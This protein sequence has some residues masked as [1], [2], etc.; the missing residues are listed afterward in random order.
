MVLDSSLNKTYRISDYIVFYGKQM[1]QITSK[2]HIEWYKVKVT[3]QILYLCQ[4]VPNFTPF[5]STTS[6]FRI[7]GH[8][9]INT[10][11]DPKMTLNNKQSTTPAS[12]IAL[13]YALQ[14]AS[15][16]VN[17]I[18]RQVYRM[19]SIWPWTLKGQS[20][21]IYMLQQPRVPNFTPFL[22]T[23]SRFRVSGHFETRD[24][25]IKLKTKLLKLPIHNTTVAWNF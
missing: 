23:G 6:L 22:S 25:Q 18:L 17:T 12:Q 21:P 4:R 3:P 16:E 20:Y 1:H 13:I 24:T 14:L 19:K 10:A 8:F 9:E 7:T 11:N 5:H 2:T 15:F